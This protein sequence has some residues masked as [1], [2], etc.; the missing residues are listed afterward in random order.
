MSGKTSAAAKNRYNRKAYDRIVISAP[1]G[2]K[3][4]IKRY[5]E[6]KG[7]SVNAFLL[8]LINAEIK[9]SAGD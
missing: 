1:K 4:I 9:Q 5:A 8:D 7:K 2:Q 3:E 6:S